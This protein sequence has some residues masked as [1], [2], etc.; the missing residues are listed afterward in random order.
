MVYLTLCPPGHL[1]RRTRFAANFYEKI[2][3]PERT[4]RDRVESSVAGV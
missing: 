2:E 1:G 4:I 3:V